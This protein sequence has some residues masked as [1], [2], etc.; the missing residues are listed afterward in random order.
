MK[1]EFINPFVTAGIGVLE[2]VISSRPEPGQLAVRSATFTTQQVSIAIGVTGGVEGHAVHGMSLVTATKIAAAMSGMPAMT[3]DE[4]ASSA[5]GELG[6][7]I[8]GNAAT[9]LSEAGYECKITPPTVVRGTD[10]EI[11]TST[12]ALVVPLHTDFGRMEINVAL[13]ESQGASARA[14]EE[15]TTAGAEA[16][17]SA[18]GSA[19][20]EAPV[21]A[22]GAARP[23]Q[24]APAP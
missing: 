18:A 23:E 12:P 8:S 21:S 3:F 22:V 7:M 17:V 5:I 9:L 13:T 20:S 19:E 24:P 11:S 10:V 14:S 16:P 4:M 1:A 2:S 15:A 6:N